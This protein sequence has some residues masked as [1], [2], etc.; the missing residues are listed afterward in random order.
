MASGEVGGFAGVHAVE[1]DGHG[2]GG[3]LVVGNGAV[4]VA[5]MK[6]WISL[7]SS[8]APSRFFSMI[9]WGSMGQGYACRGEQGNVKTRSD[10]VLPYGSEVVLHRQLVWSVATLRLSEA[11]ESIPWKWVMN[12]FIAAEDGIED[13]ARADEDRD[14]RD[15]QA[16]PAL[17][18]FRRE[19]G[20]KNDGHAEQHPCGQQSLDMAAHDLRYV[21]E[22]VEHPVFQQCAVF[23]ENG[24]N[25]HQRGGAAADQEA[26]EMRDRWWSSAAGRR[27]SRYISRTRAGR[28]RGSRASCVRGSSDR[29]RRSRGRVSRVKWV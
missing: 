2:E 7:V 27:G 1:V 12:L 28:P 26:R 3:H 15:H 5:V 11:K 6:S 23:S 17:W 18:W 24:N 19:Q 4:G 14:Q 16:D 22:E 20:R 21:E 10:R 9:H 29:P 25:V 13:H 8:S